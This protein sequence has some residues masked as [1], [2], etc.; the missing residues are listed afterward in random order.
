[1]YSSLGT[2]VQGLVLTFVRQAQK[3]NDW[4]PLALLEYLGRI[5]DD[6][7]KVKKAGQRLIELWQGATSVT[8]Y[9]PQFER[10]LF[11]AGANAWPDDAKIIT[12]VSGLNKNTRQRIDRQR[13]LPTDY[14]DFVRM[15]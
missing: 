7:N 6:P 8:V 3:D 12:L 11:E 1:M 10:L 5:Y 2:K 14:D 4:K 15:L 9:I 13:A